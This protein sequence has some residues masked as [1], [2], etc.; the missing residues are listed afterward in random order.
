MAHL[1]QRRLIG[2]LLAALAVAG[3]GWLLR[4]EAMMVDT[5]AVRRG[6]LR[7]TVT[8]EGRTRVKSLYTV[9]AAVD[10]DLERIVLDP[11]ASTQQDAV[12]ARIRPAHS[13]PL[14]ARSRAEATAAVAAAREAVARAA[15]SER[16]ASVAVEHAQSKLTRSQQLAQSNA[17]PGAEVEHTGHEVQMAKA[18]LESA[19]AAVREARAD[20]ARATAVITPSSGGSVG[21]VEVRAPASGRVLRVLRESAGPVAAGTPLLEI[22]DT[23]ELEITAD[24]L[25][26]D[27]AAVSPATAATVSG[28]GGPPVVARVRRVDPAGFTKIS[29]LGLEEQRVRVVLDLLDRPPPGLGHDYRVDVAIVVWEGKDIL[30]IPTTALFRV[31]PEWATFVMRDGRARLTQVATGLSDATSTVV[32][33]GVVDGEKVIPQPSDAIEDGTRVSV[34][35]ELKR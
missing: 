26:S 31:G 35:R 18:T 14:D 13:R 11:G 29:A 16:E 32:T 27:A 17:V 4:P 19:R 9:T 2:G 1:K 12:V 15:A 24:L 34:L 28:W 20:L 5:A 10:G 8:G 21:A 22:G 33:N 23:G 30:R 25:S 7:A 6:S 3:V